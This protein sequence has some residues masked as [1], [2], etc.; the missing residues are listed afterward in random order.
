M[1][2]ST[3]APC[4]IAGVGPSGL[5]KTVQDSRRSLFCRLLYYGIQVLGHAQ[6]GDSLFD[7]TDE[8]YVS[9]SCPQRSL[10]TKWGYVCLYDYIF[11]VIELK[12]PR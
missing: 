5:E 3:E 6:G 2:W 9:R 4:G 1:I 8:T 7:E 12:A 10:V 11:Y